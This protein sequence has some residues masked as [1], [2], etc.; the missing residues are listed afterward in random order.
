MQID[1]LHKFKRWLKNKSLK[2][3]ISTIERGTEYIYVTYQKYSKFG[4]YKDGF[5]S[6]Q[7][8]LET[9]ADK[10]KQGNDIVLK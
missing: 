7:N 1:I 3:Q 6:F 10:K 2:I 8:E 4:C 9:Y 5:T